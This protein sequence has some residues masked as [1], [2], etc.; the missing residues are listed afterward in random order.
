MESALWDLEE[1][2]IAI[3]GV[4]AQIANGGEEDNMG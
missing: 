2:H 3:W 1:F 4:E